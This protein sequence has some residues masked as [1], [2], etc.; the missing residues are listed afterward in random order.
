[1]SGLDRECAQ[2]WPTASLVCRRRRRPGSN[3]RQ[4]R[5]VEVVVALVRRRVHDGRLCVV[6]A[7][8]SIVRVRALR[9]VQVGRHVKV[10][11]HVPRRRRRGNC[12]S[13]RNLAREVGGVGVNVLARVAV[14]RHWPQLTV[15]GGGGVSA[16][17]V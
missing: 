6:C 2:I 16:A 10:G 1:V 8:T 12:V 13:V 7:W 3:G 5:R 17:E 4:V 9:S 15:A 14:H 11:I